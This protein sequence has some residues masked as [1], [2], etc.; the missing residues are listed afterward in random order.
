[1]RQMK[2]EQ[3][4]L[5]HC[6]YMSVVVKRYTGGGVNV[7]KE[8]KRETDRQV[9]RTSITIWLQIALDGNICF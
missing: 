8:P 9:D 1:M 4:Y 2:Y 6:N 3:S 5:F 7:K